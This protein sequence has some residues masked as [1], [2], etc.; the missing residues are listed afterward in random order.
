MEDICPIF[1]KRIMF[2]GG[3]KMAFWAVYGKPWY[4]RKDLENQ[5]YLFKKYLYKEWYNSLSDEERNKVDE[6]RKRK[7]EERL[8][9]L[10]RFEAQFHVLRNLYTK[11]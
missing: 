8:Q 5:I 2:K 1:L 9:S 7:A 10:A 4:K 3:C 6:T 11:Y